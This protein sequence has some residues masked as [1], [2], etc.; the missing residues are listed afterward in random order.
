MLPWIKDKKEYIDVL[1]HKGLV[2]DI[3]LTDDHS[4]NAE[5]IKGFLRDAYPDAQDF[6]RGGVSQAVFGLERER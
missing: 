1:H 2:W 6:V 3:V 5:E 4:L